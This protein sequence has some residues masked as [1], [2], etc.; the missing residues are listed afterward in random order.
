MNKFFIGQYVK[1]NTEDEWN[2]S[3]GMITS[4]INN[5]IIIFCMNKPEYNYFVK[6]EEADKILEIINV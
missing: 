4:L 6:Y 5:I 3:Y 1:L 2:S